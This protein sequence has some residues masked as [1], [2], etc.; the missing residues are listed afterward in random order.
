MPE[1]QPTTPDVAG[2][3]RTPT[4]EISSPST[5]TPATETIVRPPPTPTKPEVS[6]EKAPSDGKEAREP[7]KSVL[8]EKS[9]EEGAP[10]TYADFTVPEGFE[11]DPD[12][13][14]EAGALFKKQNL[15]QS[16]G[17]ELVDF[18][19]NKTK[20]A[21]EAP[22]RAY[23]DKRAE[24]RSEISGDAKIGGTKLNETMASISKLVDSFGDAKVSEAF[25][26]AMDYTGAG[27]HPAVVRGLHAIALKLTEGGAVRGGGPSPE[28]QRQ[29]N[30]P[31]RPTAAQSIYPNLPSTQRG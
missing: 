10:A 28:G 7:R 14:K 4:G 27:D 6:V 3:T 24:W 20:E 25:R 2:V 16:Q 21:F 23:Q 8:N 30:T 29:P 18:Y 22:F 26:D 19:V 5:S 31:E 11:L 13:A 12:I 15:T 1:T 9:P 17:Q